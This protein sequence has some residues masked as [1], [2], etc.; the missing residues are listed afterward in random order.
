MALP[1]GRT[2]H[3]ARPGA[4]PFVPGMIWMAR[5]YRFGRNTWKRASVMHAMAVVVFT[6]L[7][8]VL[9]IGMRVPIFVTAYDEYALR[10]FEVHALNGDYVVVLRD[11]TR[12]TLSRG[13]REKLQQRLAK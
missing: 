3:A 8:A 6:F 11:G 13:Y 7:H 10:A 12:L 2:A 9:T 1:E 5:R 4:E